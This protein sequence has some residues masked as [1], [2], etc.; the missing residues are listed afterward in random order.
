MYH[1]V[2]RDTSQSP[3]ISTF[4][5]GKKK[6]I[7]IFLNPT[8]YEIKNYDEEDIRYEEDCIEDNYKRIYYNKFILDEEF[9]IDEITYRI[10]RIND[11][12][13][14]TLGYGTPNLR[15]TIFNSYNS[16]NDDEYNEEDYKFNEDE[17]DELDE[18][19]KS[20]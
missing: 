3:F 19:Q 13:I 11:F 15:R 7:I 17:L 5:I 8:I 14:F 20:S 1:G 4:L 2:D 12:S 6:E 9:D 18:I 10:C 16:R